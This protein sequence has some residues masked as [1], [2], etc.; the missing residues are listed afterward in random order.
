M[1]QYPTFLITRLNSFCCIRY[2]KLISTTYFVKVTLHNS[3]TTIPSFHVSCALFCKLTHLTG[4]ILI[5]FMFWSSL[6]ALI[7]F[8]VLKT[9]SGWKTKHEVCFFFYIFFCDFM[10]HSSWQKKW[11]ETERWG[12]KEVFL[13]FW[14]IDSQVYQSINTTLNLVIH[15]QVILW[16]TL[17]FPSTRRDEWCKENINTA[18]DFVIMTLVWKSSVV[19]GY[20]EILWSKS[21]CSEQQHQEES[22][23]WSPDTGGGWW[24]FWDRWNDEAG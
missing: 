7:S 3:S 23:P 12:E 5:Y 1:A 8:R 6:I 15:V 4:H 10:K 17:C 16:E 2:E 24:V 9:E 22:P 19:R 21:V 14:L 13:C 18:D 20:V 11:T